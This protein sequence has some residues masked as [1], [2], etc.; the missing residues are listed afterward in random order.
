MGRCKHARE[1]KEEA[2]K[3]GKEN[4]VKKTGSGVQ[5]C[6]GEVRNRF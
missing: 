6:G 2:G 3:E 4:R 5:I 1:I